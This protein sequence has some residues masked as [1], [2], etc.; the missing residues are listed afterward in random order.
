MRLVG[1]SDRRSCSAKLTFSELGVEL[2]LNF[3]QFSV[4]EGNHLISTARHFH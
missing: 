1:Q 2:L 4:V 3:T